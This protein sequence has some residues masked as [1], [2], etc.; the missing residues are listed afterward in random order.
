MS[1]LW[2][3]SK[4][5]LELI[6]EPP[7]RPNSDMAMILILCQ[8]DAPTRTI[9]LIPWLSRRTPL[10]SGRTSFPA[11]TNMDLPLWTARKWD[12]RITTGEGQ[13]GPTPSPMYNPLLAAPFHRSGLPVLS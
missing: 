9:S 7:S 6:R 13:T 10:F 4:H 12:L 8:H 2:K 1:K 11:M 5:D 3:W